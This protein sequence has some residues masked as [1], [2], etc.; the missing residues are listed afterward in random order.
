VPKPSFGDEEVLLRVASVGLDGTDREIN[1]GLYGVPPEGSDYLILGHEALASVEELGAGVSGFSTGELV[2]PTVRRPDDCMNCNEGESDMCLTGNYKEHGIKELHGFAAEYAKTEAAFLVKVPDELAD[3]GVLLEPV[4]IVEKAYY[5]TRKIQERVVWEPRTALVLGA[6]SL[7]LLATLLLR[8]EGLAVLTVATQPQESLKAHLVEQTGA[9]YVN[10]KETPV[11]SLGANF[12]FIFEATGSP[13]VAMDAL[14]L[15]RPN[16]VA[17]FLGIY[18]DR[19]VCQDFGKIATSIVLG[20][21]LCFG[22]VNANRSYF[23]RGLVHLAEMK[24]RYRDVLRKLFTST[25]RPEEYRTA[26]EPS[27]DEIKTVIEFAAKS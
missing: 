13:Q 16:G 20:N 9:Q 2:V 23:E 14:E 22:S 8:L 17:C 26:F 12:D 25:L 18:R 4:S 5:Q 21:R 10:A 6:G 27:R 19:V 24:A 15:L 3:V 1:G 7:G 11:T